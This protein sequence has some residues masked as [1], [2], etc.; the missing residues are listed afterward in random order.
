VLRDGAELFVE[1]SEP[2]SRDVRRPAPTVP[3]VSDP[4]TER[5]L[6]LVLPTALTVGGSEMNMLRVVR[7]LRDRWAVVIVTTDLHDPRRGSLHAL[8]DEVSALVIDLAE[9]GP[10][11]SHFELLGLLCAALSIDVVWTS[12]GS[13]LWAGNVE[14]IRSTLA[15]SAIVDQECYDARKGWIERF[16]V[17]PGLSKLDRYIAQGE[18]LRRAFVREHHIPSV[19]VDLIPPSIDSSRFAPSGVDRRHLAQTWNLPPDAQ[20]FALIGRLSA[21]K[22]PLEFLDLARRWRYDW[23]VH[24]LLV[25]SGDLH[26]EVANAIRLGELDNVTWSPFV[27][28]TWAIY[29][30]LSGLVIAS[31]YEGTPLVLVEALAMGIPVLSTDVGNVRVALEEHET[32]L[33]VQ[34]FSGAALAEGLDVFRQQLGRLT[35]NARSSAEEIRARH[36]AR[37][38][39]TLY[40]RSFA[41]ARE[42]VAARRRP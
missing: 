11:E 9:L 42:R 35:D 20:I 4:D 41:T 16:P 23:G 27:E 21:E 28:D 33:V 31:T 38:V 15:L 6:L 36:D 34:G 32:G 5:P 19:R 18:P 29:P 12:N 37:A 39:A 3:V 7:V 25:G 24:F 14:Q 2:A 8:A 26:H 1:R 40:E 13:E 10:P 17:V 22:Q 30:L